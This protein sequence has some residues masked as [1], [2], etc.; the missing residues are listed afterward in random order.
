MDQ[1][2]LFIIKSRSLLVSDLLPK[3]RR[4]LASLSEDQIWWRP[5]STSNSIGNLVLHLDGNVRQ[6]IL[7]GVGGLPDQ[8]VRQQEFDETGPINP[9]ELLKRLTAT[10]AAVDEVLGGLEKQTLLEEREIQGKPRNV[11][12]AVYHVVEHFSMHTGQIILMT[13]MLAERD[14]EFHSDS[15]KTPV[16]PTAMPVKAQD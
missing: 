11:L 16:P 6:W 7:S 10:I 15:T 1:A 2:E 12:D 4:C 8:R 3:I 5:N 9:D 14:L 13:K